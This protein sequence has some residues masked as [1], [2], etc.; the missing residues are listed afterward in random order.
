VFR[1]D[2]GREY[3]AMKPWLEEQGIECQMTAPH[4]PA[5]NGVAERQNRTLTELMRAMMGE[6]LLPQTLWSVTISHAAYIRNRS[7]TRA[8]DEKTPMEAWTGNKPNL[9]H[10]R[11]FGCDVWILDEGDRAKTQPKSNKFTFIGFVKGSKSI[12]YWNPRT[13]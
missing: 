4:S 5:Q 11:E 7:P 3:I 8:L 1:C 12:R 10:L 13:H 6:K 9:S 2:N